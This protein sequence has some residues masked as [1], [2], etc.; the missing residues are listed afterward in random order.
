MSDAS[1]KD[2][3]HVEIEL[4]RRRFSFQSKSTRRGGKS[5]E[6]KDTI[7]VIRQNQLQ[8]F[9]DYLSRARNGTVLQRAGA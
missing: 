9:K 4:H 2:G 1:L 5:A 6:Y 3:G 8:F 7:L